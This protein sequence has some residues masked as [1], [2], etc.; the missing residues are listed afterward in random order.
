MSEM[1]PRC[2]SRGKTWQGADPKCAFPGGVF[3]TDNWNCATMGALREL[4]AGEGDFGPGK[5]GVLCRHDDSAAGLIPFETAN[6]GLPSGRGLDNGFIALAWYKQRGRTDAAV[7]I[8][9]SGADPVQEPL[10]LE[11]AEY[12]LTR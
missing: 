3:S 11:I 1:C 2:Q 9:D 10:T 4:V 12:T 5:A 7:V 6:N 8:R